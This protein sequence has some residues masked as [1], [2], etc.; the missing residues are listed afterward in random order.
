[1]EETRYNGPEM[2]LRK[3]IVLLLT[4]ALILTLFLTRTCRQEPVRE[5]VPEKTVQAV[6]HIE[7]SP[8][9]S[10]FQEYADSMFD[11][12]LLAAI[13]YV[14]SKFDSTA[15]SCRGA[16]G[17]MQIM[18]STYRHILRRM[19][20]DTTLQSTELDV[21]V[22][23]R[24]LHHLSDQFSF[25][26]EKER[27]NYILGSYNGGAGHI[28]DAMRL[29]RRDGTNRYRWDSLTP[30]LESL[31]D[32]RVYTDSLCRAGSFDATETLAYVRKVTYIYNRYRSR[33]LIYQAAERL[34]E[35]SNNE[36]RNYDRPEDV[37]DESPAF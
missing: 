29:A 33:D 15:V 27:L 19:G 5:T 13:A 4:A 16:E 20:I 28:F 36:V 17:I 23:V 2:S 12:T 18:P 14:E 3:V 24:Y 34:M 22:A 25:I 26:N 37:V 7:I 21:R 11:W 31:S 35:N 9:D 6:H 30:V 10:L 1:M 32:E 8:Y